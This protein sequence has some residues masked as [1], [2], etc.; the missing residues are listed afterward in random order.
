MFVFASV[1]GGAIDGVVGLADSQA[2]E[3][4]PQVDMIR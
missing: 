3:T 2:S 1:L 4:R